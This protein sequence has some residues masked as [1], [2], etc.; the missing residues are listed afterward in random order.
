MNRIGRYA[1]TLT[2]TGV[3]LTACA[4]DNLPTDPI[5]EPGTLAEAALAANNSWTA[6]AVM[7]TGRVSLAAA[8]L[9]NAQ[10]Q[11]LLYAIGGD[12]GN[13]VT[14]STV[15]AFN[16]AT[17][18]WSTKASLPVRL[19]E[20]NGA[21]A[22]G[23][24][25]YVSGGRDLDNNSPGSDDG[26]PRKSLYMYDRGSD[27]WSRKADM[28]QPSIGG[29][30]GV[31]NGKLYVLNPSFDR[32]YRY[33]PATNVWSTLPKCPGP[34]FRAAAAVI[35]GK[36]YVAGGERFAINGPIAIRRLHVY[37]PATNRWTEKAP[38]PHA[39]SSA[40]GARLLGRFYVLG[41]SAN[42]RGRDYAQAYDPVTNTWSLKT[43]LPTFRTALAAAN[44]VN[45]NGQQRIVAVG[46]F[47]GAGARFLKSTD[48]YTP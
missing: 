36:F 28:P 35:G 48:V 1:L 26:A 22:V 27:S 33:N 44:F 15:E 34:H 47:G 37:D 12:D 41:G 38:M 24:K 20:T 10:Q 6:K 32:F 31:I 21:A 40:A 23:G 4:E 3:G 45:P 11:P 14:L 46:G 25:I 29:V 17:N 18:S 5:A 16:T 42:G 30:T 19:E 8:V 13:G 7:P 43:P 2:L 39:V 9:N